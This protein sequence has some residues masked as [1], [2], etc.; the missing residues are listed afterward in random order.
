MSEI[1]NSAEIL[2]KDFGTYPPVPLQANNDRSKVKVSVKPFGFFRL[3][4]FQAKV[5]TLLVKA[6]AS[7]KLST[8]LLTTDPGL[9]K[10]L[11]VARASFKS[12]LLPFEHAVSNIHAQALKSK[13]IGGIQLFGL[14]IAVCILF[15]PLVLACVYF[16]F[17]LTQRSHKHTLAFFFPAHFSANAVMYNARIKSD[18]L[19][20]YISHEHL[21]LLQT[22][23]EQNLRKLGAAVDLSIPHENDLL[24]ESARQGEY[25]TYI[26]Y[27]MLRHE[28]EARLHELVL[29]YYR[30][31]KEL[32]LS[33][34]EFLRMVLHFEC[35]ANPIR[36]KYQKLFKELPHDNIKTITPRSAHMM[37]DLERIV[38]SLSGEDTV[39]AYLYEVLP[40]MYANLLHYYGD[41][42]ASERMKDSIPS[43]DLYQ[44]M[45]SPL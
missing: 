7:D 12:V 29:V 15:L 8:V 27:L 41:S 30:V 16:I 26:A 45:F 3:L 32:P 13:L 21:H 17:K 4:F 2:K 25:G 31:A 11:S 14:L 18:D 39:K 19:D 40:R 43:I 44:S 6:C 20:W 9:M 36:A 5:F 38:V 23:Y 35:F 34:N 10:Q 33:L 22:L 1:T 28:T 42:A 37:R 24:K